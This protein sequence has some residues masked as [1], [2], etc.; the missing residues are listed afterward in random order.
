MA[1][2]GVE[3]TSLKETFK[4]TIRK[5]DVR[6]TEKDKVEMY[7][8]FRPGDIVVGRVLTLHTQTYLLSTAE[9]ELG[10]VFA[11]SEA[12]KSELIFT[13]ISKEFLC[14]NSPKINALENSQTMI[15]LSSW[16]VCRPLSINVWN[17]QVY[18]PPH[19]LFAA[20]SYLIFCNPFRVR[21]H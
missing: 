17:C 4:G 18:H 8:S 11:K 12:G 14:L 10:V 3:S 20:C 6:A 7:K 15:V 19:S 2:L 16:K 13:K 1:I 5:E 21:I 9:N